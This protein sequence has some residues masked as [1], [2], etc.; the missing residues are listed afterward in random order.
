MPMIE[1][2]R[3]KKIF[4]NRSK[5]DGLCSPWRRAISAP[6]AAQGR[7]TGMN[8]PTAMADEINKDD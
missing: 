2:G 4:V 3:N 1:Q 5:F 8:E 6:T 7:M